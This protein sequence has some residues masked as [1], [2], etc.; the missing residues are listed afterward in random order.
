MRRCYARRMLTPRSRLGAGFFALSASLALFGCKKKD[1]ASY[2]TAPVIYPGGSPTAPGA[3]AAPAPPMS[4]PGSVPAGMPPAAGFACANDADVQCPFGRCVQGRCGGCTDGRECKANAQCFPTWF[5]SACLPANA[6]STAGTPPPAP[7]P[8]A[9]PIPVTPTPGAPS[10]PTPAPSSDPVARA[11]SLCVAR[12][13]DYRAR[14]GAPPVTQRT[15]KESCGDAQAR[16]DAQTRTAH[17]SFGQCRE[18][19][20]NECP[21]WSGSLDVVVERCLAM[22][23]AEGPGSGPEH[24][25]YVNMT[26]RNYRGVACGIFS[27]TNGEI[28]MVHD[29][30]R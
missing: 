3:P 30:F 25:H 28:W 6:Q 2:Q 10:Q 19:A 12:I 20:Q 23:F 26:D 5:G 18:S 16:S 29:F 8:P 4:P 9:A 21:G 7:A 13:N 27:G 22:M 14:V 15:D 17:G 24:G 1:A 11:R